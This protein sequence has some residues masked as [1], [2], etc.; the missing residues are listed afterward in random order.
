VIRRRSGRAYDPS[1]AAA[2]LDDPSG[3]LAVSDVDDPWGA[4]LEA[5]P[6][7][8]AWIPHGQLEG[9]L[10]AFADF[11]DLAS[12][13]LR[14][15]SPGVAQLAAAAGTVA[16]LSVEEVRRLRL[17]GLVHDLGR[18]GVPTGI[19][20]HP[21]PLTVDARERVRLHSYL[22]ERILDR[23]NVLAPLARIAACHH[24]RVD[25]SGYHRGA[26][27]PDLSRSERL[28]AAADAYQALSEARPHRPP[29]SPGAA[30]ERLRRDARSGLFDPSDVEAVLVAAGHAPSPAVSARPAHLTDREIEVLRLIARGRSNREV[31]AELVISAKTVGT[32][33]EHIYA[34]AGVTTRAGATLFA[35]QHGLL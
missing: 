26:R 17:A 32:H 22:T 16:G 35:M 12:P 5:E 31:A 18:V 14:G 1:V 19:W 20:D 2:F 21:G 13:W 15:H 24:E 27:G 8:W 3:L 4:T 10:A 34:K 23:S 7:P 9:M 6:A 25:G 30:C 33:V 28:L 11:V 29:H